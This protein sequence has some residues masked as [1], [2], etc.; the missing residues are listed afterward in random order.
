M[1]PSEKP[2]T[3]RSRSIEE[4]NSLTEEEA[5]RLSPEDTVRW[6]DAYEVQQKRDQRKWAAVNGLKEW[7]RFALQVAIL[8]PVCLSLLFLGVELIALIIA[9][10][11]AEPFVVT[12][13]TAGYIQTALLT[14][15]LLGPVAY[16][17]R[18]YL[19][20]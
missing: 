16:K 8:G 13:E 15:I 1:I 19:D 4:W 20:P 14:L 3:Q 2:R 5:R 9:G 12:R 17:M 7:V 11:G 10:L 6:I 18:N